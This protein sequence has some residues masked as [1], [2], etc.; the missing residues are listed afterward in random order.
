MARNAAKKRWI[1]ALVLTVGV[2][3]CV[4]LYYA[5]QKLDTPVPDEVRYD[6][7]AIMVPEEHNMFRAGEQPRFAAAAP[8][9]L[10]AP[11]AAAVSPV[12]R[13]AKADVTAPAPK[14]AAAAPVAKAAPAPAPAPQPRAIV[15]PHL[16][17][18]EKP[19]AAFHPAPAK[20]TGA[21]QTAALTLAPAAKVTLA[22]AAA[23]ARAAKAPKAPKNAAPASLAK[24][25][26]QPRGNSEFSQAFA[27]F[28]APVDASVQLELA[29]PTIEPVRVGSPAA[30]FASASAPQLE[31]PLPA[32][33]VELPPVTATADTPEAKL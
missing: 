9:E 27:S 5:Q 29:L 10:A 19:A 21:S 23:P 30:D 4:G 24:L 28:D 18:V 7:T 32:P 8:Q 3:D 25:V 22:K 12:T 15:T 1:K 11:A 20:L 17:K 16:A 31:T 26:P 2:A 13:L 6:R 33:T 14:L